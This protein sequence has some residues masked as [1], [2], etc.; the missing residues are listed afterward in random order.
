MTKLMMMRNP[1]LTVNSQ[2]RTRIKT[3][4]KTRIKT[5]TKI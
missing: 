3:K 1:K 4:T 2:I 5:K